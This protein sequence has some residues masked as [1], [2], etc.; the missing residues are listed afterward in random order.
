VT[1]Q[2]AGQGRTRAA[3]SVIAV[4]LAVAMSGCA[5]RKD[6]VVVGGS[7]NFVA[8]GGRTQIP[9]DPP[10]SR[11][12][13]SGLARDDLLRPGHKI[14]LAVFPNT[15]VALNSWGSW[16]GPCRLEAADLE[17]TC[18]A[19]KASGVTV[20][21]IDVRDDVRDAAV[22]FVRERAITYPS[23]DDPPGRS[24]GALHGFPRNTAPATIV[25]DRAHR[26]AMV[27]PGP[28][29][30]LTTTS[31][32]PTSR[33]RTSHPHRARSL[34]RSR[35]AW[36][37][38]GRWQAVSGLTEFVISG[39][40]AVGRAAGGR[41]RRGLLRLTLLPPT[42]A[43]LSGLPQRPGREPHD[44]PRANLDHE[45]NAV[46]VEPGAAGRRGYAVRG[47]FI[48]VFAAEA[49]SALGLSDLLALTSRSC[50]A[51]AAASRS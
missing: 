16:C 28:N 4:L 19:T 1:P 25:L 7:F 40:A 24:L 30:D 22:D 9:Y 50:N 11:G 35:G 51:S 37:F 2:Q 32:G 36:G 31:G 44:S 39:P 43:R 23:I 42:G 27:F 14:G 17:Q 34:R 10:A 33:R 21:G 46:G 49:T 18:Q 15:V 13:V 8:P 48:T 12:T 45:R 6:A 26:V 29:P 20:L 47:R 5:T 3:R 41:R 38:P